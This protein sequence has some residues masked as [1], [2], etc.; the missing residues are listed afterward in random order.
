MI[1]KTSSTVTFTQLVGGVIGIAIAGT[2]FGNSLVSQLHHYAPDLD[3]TVS[4]N[5]RSSV[6]Y[7]FT[8]PLEQQRPVIQAYSRA[9]GYVFVLAIP[10]G[11]M[12]SASAL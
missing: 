12:A 9:V 5:V 8:L 7:I 6:T 1:P 4:T 3:A 2:I 10:S 11:I